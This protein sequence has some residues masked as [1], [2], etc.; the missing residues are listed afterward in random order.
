MYFIINLIL[1]SFT[2]I[3][4]YST[5][6]GVHFTVDLE[7]TKSSF[8]NTTFPISYSCNL[9]ST[10]L[11]PDGWIHTF[12][13]VF[14]R[15]LPGN[16]FNNVSVLQIPSCNSQDAGRYRFKWRGDALGLNISNYL[17]DLE[18]NGM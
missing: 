3:T 18:V 10:T 2:P 11:S 9:T 14:I 4:M 16:T 13:G 8:C 5:I 1:K 6:I 15:K 7:M 17:S 12:N